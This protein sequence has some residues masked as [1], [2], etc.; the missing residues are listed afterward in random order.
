MAKSKYTFEKR[1]KELDRKKKKEDKRKRKQEKNKAT[2]EGI[3]NQVQNEG[4]ST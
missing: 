4:E 1:Q 3:S 2:Q